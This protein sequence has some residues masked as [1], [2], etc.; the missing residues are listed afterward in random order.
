MGK[1]E[2]FVIPTNVKPGDLVVFDDDGP[3]VAKKTVAKK[4]ACRKCCFY[5]ASGF[6]CSLLTAILCGNSTNDKYGVYFV[7]QDTASMKAK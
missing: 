5:S 1:R 2:L 6:D 7:K 3:Y 4:G